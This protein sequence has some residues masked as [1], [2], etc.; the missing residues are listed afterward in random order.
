[1]TR[2]ALV[3]GVLFGLAVGSVLSLVMTTLDYL[4]NPAGIF[5]DEL[6]VNWGRVFETWFSWLVPV[7]LLGSI[8]AVPILLWMSR[9]R[10]KL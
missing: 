8:V 5:H 6:G 7:A 4:H 10:H 1:M 9:P 3:R 2:R